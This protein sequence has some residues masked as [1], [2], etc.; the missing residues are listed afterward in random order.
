[1]TERSKPEPKRRRIS[2]EFESFMKEIS[3]EMD[4][5]G[6]DEPE[7]TLPSSGTSEQAEIIGDDEKTIRIWPD[8]ADRILEE[9]R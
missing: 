6:S 3:E 2:R 5:S 8:L 1:M 7:A 4:M 9:M